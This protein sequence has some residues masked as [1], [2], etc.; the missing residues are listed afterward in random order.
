MFILRPYRETDCAEYARLFYDTIHTVNAA[1]YT[2]AELDAWADGNVDL[3]KWNA[4]FLEHYTITAEENGVIVGFGDMDDRGYL[5]RLYIHRE[6]QRRGIAAAICDRLEAYAAERADT[7]ETHASI[8]A[9][10]F[11]LRRGYEVVREQ[12]VCRHGVYLTN[13][14]MVKRL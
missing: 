12:Q 5:D 7:V 4:S 13:F 6:H 8:T 1:D 11:F 14:V 3:A 2:P 10:P 9:K